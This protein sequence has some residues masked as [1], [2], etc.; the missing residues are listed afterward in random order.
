MSR[1]VSIELNNLNRNVSFLRSF[2]D[3][4]DFNK[5]NNFTETSISKTRTCIKTFSLY[6]CKTRMI[7][8]M[9]EWF[10]EWIISVIKC[11]I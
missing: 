9:F 7:F 6:I 3:I 1:K 11:I 10:S 8:K 4:Q 5:F 2:F